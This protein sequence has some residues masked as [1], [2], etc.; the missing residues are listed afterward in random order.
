MCMWHLCAESVPSEAG[1]DGRSGRR[2]GGAAVC[3]SQAK[4]RMGIIPSHSAPTAQHLCRSE[5]ETY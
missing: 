4:C 3:K 1:T 2:E 5:R